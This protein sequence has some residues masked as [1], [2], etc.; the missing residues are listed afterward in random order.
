MCT[1]PKS[2]GVPCEHKIVR[3]FS[4]VCFNIVG[5]QTSM[6]SSS[7]LHVISSIAVENDTVEL[8]TT[9]ASRAQRLSFK[10][11]HALVGG[12]RT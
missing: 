4:F 3:T 9:P 12:R 5:K 6:L 11:L 8:A 2:C 1:S 10:V 7:Q